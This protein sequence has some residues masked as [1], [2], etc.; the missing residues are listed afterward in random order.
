[1]AG[2]Q[3][4][5]FGAR[6]REAVLRE[7]SR[8]P[9]GDEA[10]RRLRSFF[11]RDWEDLKRQDAIAALEAARRHLDAGIHAPHRPGG[12]RAPARGADTE[13]GIVELLERGAWRSDGVLVP[14]RTIVQRA[15]EAGIIDARQL[16]DA[17]ARFYLDR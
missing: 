10:A 16:R 9:A 2:A 6:S 17:S 7:A 1:L 3:S 15:A 13:F 5:F 12:H 8:L 14:L 11:E 4:C